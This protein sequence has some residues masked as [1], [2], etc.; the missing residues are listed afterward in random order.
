VFLASPK[1]QQVLKWDWFGVVLI[2]HV[3]KRS[4]GEKKGDA[5]TNRLFVPHSITVEKSINKTGIT[6]NNTQ[7][8][9]EKNMTNRD[10]N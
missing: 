2:P 10:E 8:F 7:V 1:V 3:C 5:I 4:E 9:S 6:R